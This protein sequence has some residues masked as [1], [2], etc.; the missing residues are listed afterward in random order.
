MYV[1]IY[2]YMYVCM[3]VYIHTYT[4]VHSYT[5][6]MLYYQTNFCGYANLIAHMTKCRIC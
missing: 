1:C 5:I 6:P 2:I 4:Y 3:Y